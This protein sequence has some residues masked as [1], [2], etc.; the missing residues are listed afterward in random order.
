MQIESGK[1][2]FIR[3]I[4]GYSAACAVGIAYVIF[5]KTAGY[6]I[7]CIFHFVTGLNCI[8]CGVT[9]M[10]VYLL[11]GDIYDAYYTNRLLFITL[12][13]FVFYIIKGSIQYVKNGKPSYSRTDKTVF[14]GFIVAAAIFGIVRNFDILL[15]WQIA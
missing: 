5:Y 6:G 4:A 7:P 1:K 10:L 8:S 2:R 14:I 9:R 15:N 12:P 11:Q 3:L 13:L